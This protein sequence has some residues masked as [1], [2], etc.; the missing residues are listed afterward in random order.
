MN[1]TRGKNLLT[2]LCFKH[3][4]RSALTLVSCCVLVV[5]AVSKLA[6]VVWIKLVSIER[7]MLRQD[8][9]M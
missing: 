1:L 8:A 2:T 4:M 6:G 5:T 9:K 3:G 7:V